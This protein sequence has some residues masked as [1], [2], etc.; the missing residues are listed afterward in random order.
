MLLSE[1]LDSISGP[2][3]PGTTWCA[4]SSLTV[5]VYVVPPFLRWVSSVHSL[6]G[7]KNHGK[8][9]AETVK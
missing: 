4:F 5:D 9:K 8:S 6:L 1:S 7:N 3:Q 2:F